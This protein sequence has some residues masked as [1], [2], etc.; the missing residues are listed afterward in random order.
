M[1]ISRLSLW[2]VSG[3]VKKA[4]STALITI[5]SKFLTWTGS[6]SSESNTLESR[7]QR[8]LA[9]LARKWILSS[10]YKATKPISQSQQRISSMISSGKASTLL[11]MLLI[12]S[13]LVYTLTPVVF[14]TRSLS[15]SRER[16]AQKLTPRW[17]FRTRPSAMET[18]KIHQK[19]Q[20]QCA[21]WEISLIWSNIVSSGAETH[22]T[23]SLWLGLKTRSALLI[24]QTRLYNR[25]LATQLLLQW[26]TNSTRSK[27][28]LSLRARQTLLTVYKS[29]E[30]SSM[31]TST[32]PSGTSC[33]FIHLMLRTKTVRSSG[34]A[35]SVAQA[36]FFS[37]LKMIL[38]YCLW[39]H[40][41][42]WLHSILVLFSKETWRSS[43][44]SHLTRRPNHTCPN[45]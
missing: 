28:S 17:L 9:A 27:R 45:K 7:S 25:L 15:L 31:N 21:P 12:T 13:K 42:T 33:S 19:N 39:L 20:S 30:I 8:S 4:R 6:S 34:Q 43:D 3:A 36:L 22:S 41:P 16:L 38:S 14:G 24:A 18:H 10:T 29:Q 1:N 37:M 32:L 35:Q 26:L 2:W 44:R 11:S 5:I 23:H 40:V